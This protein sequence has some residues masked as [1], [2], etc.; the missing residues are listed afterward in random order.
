NKDEEGSAA[1][2]VEDGWYKCPVRAFGTYWLDIDT[3]PPA[4]KSG[5]KENANLGKAKQITLNVKDAQ[6]SVKKFNGYID[7]KW[8]CFE[9]HG[10]SFFYKFDEHCS[11][12]KHKLLF[13]AEDE[14]ANATTY[15]LTF[16]R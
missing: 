15:T 16:T 3:L 1:A 8:V 10:S 2:P 5:H 13:K 11:R 7:D 6:T 9:Q 14:N 4:V 12:G